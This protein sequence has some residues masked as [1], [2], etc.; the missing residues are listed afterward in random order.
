[1]LERFKEYS[2][3]LKKALEEFDFVFDLN[4]ALKY[5][6]EYVFLDHMHFTNTG[7]SM[8]AKYIFEIMKKQG[9][10]KNSTCQ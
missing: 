7:N 1:M 5:T 2:D 3:E 4:E 9:I 10:I 8:C 6:Q